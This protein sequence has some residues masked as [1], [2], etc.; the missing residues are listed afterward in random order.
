MENRK[1]LGLLGI[2]N[3]GGN[4]QIGEDPVG[5]LCKAGR[6]RLLILASDAADHTC[7]RANSFASLHKTPLVV[8]DQDKSGLG[9]VFGR[10]SVAMAAISDISLAESFL[11]ALDQPERYEAQLAQVHDKAEYMKARKK[12]KPRG[13][14]KQGKR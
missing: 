13:T 8:I 7:R 1:A 5:N 3:K 10:N 12:A 2:A 11:K 4:V 9:A 6:A 14:G